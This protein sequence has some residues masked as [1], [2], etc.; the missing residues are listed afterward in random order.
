MHSHLP[1]WPAA[2][3]LDAYLRQAETAAAD[4]VGVVEEEDAL[5][6]QMGKVDAVSAIEKEHRALARLHHRQTGD[7]QCVAVERAALHV[8]PDR[9]VGR[10]LER[11]FDLELD[12]RHD[13]AIA[14]AVLA[15]FRAHRARLRDDHTL[16]ARDALIERGDLGIGRTGRARRRGDPDYGGGHTSSES[17]VVVHQQDT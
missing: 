14:V 11:L 5:A 2:R 12:A 15:P 17:I 9:V 1:Y 7:M 10:A 6:A 13:Q 8:H 16:G 3:V 4:D